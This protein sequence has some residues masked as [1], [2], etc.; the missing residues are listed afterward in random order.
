MPALTWA[1]I[2][3]FPAGA[4]VAALVARSECRL[5]LFVFGG[6]FILSTPN[7]DWSKLIY[8]TACLLACAIALFRADL[9]SGGERRLLSATAIVGSIGLISFLVALFRGIAMVE[10]FRAVV[11]I[12]LIA[13][14]PLFAIDSSKSSAGRLIVAEFVTAGIVAGLAYA[15]QRNSRFVPTHMFWT[16]MMPAALFAYAC[17]AAMTGRAYRFVWSVVAALVLIEMLFSAE[18]S[19]W[20]ILAIPLF[21]MTTRARPVVA[22]VGGLA[23]LGCLVVAGFI[24]LLPSFTAMIGVRQDQMEKRLFSVWAASTNP[25]SDKSNLLRILQTAQLARAFARDP[26]FGTGPG[27]VFP[28]VARGYLVLSTSVNDSPMEFPAKYGL[29]GVVLLLAAV[30]QVVRFGR[31]RARAFGCS[32]ALRALAAYAIFALIASIAHSPIVDKGFSFGL[33]F[34]LA[35][36]LFENREEHAGRLLITDRSRR[37]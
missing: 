14:A 19:V 33:A 35:L 3:L 12:F 11:P 36:S 26:I 34:L 24:L 4:V 13:L 20:G 1:L 32:P 16:L 30:A 10:W 22:E 5:A 21:I 8:M 23:A 7:L 18:R 9:R 17:A 2:A 31:E 37:R 29:V 28:S 27:K 25:R 6:L 15:V